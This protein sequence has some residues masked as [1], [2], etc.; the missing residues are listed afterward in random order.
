MPGRTPKPKAEP[1][2]Y[3]PGW[4]PFLASIRE[5]ID[6][7]TPRLVFADWLQENGDEPRAELIRLQC[8]AARGDA[9]AGRR[10]DQLLPQHRRRWLRGL[11]QSL[12]DNPTRCTFR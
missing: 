4:E 3:P 8:A 10:A 2:P 5:N 7:D 6:E 11:P 9:A 1:C 12:A